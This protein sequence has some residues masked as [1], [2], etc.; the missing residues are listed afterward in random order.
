MVRRSARQQNL[1]QAMMT[2]TLA[3][4]NHRF[5]FQPTPN[6]ITY[7]TQKLTL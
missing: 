7:Q 3:Q 6:T 5:P 4:A 2:K 1:S